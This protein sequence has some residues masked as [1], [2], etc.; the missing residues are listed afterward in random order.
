MTNAQ[1]KYAEL[2]WTA[3]DIIDAA[4]NRDQQI[5]E[6]QAEAWLERNSNHIQERLC[7]LGWDV[8]DNIM[9]WDDPAK[10]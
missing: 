4:A 7:E 8:I 3:E 9:A 5:T 10:E 2:A 6:E 1:H